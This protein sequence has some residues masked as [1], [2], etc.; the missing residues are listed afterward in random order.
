[1]LHYMY[2]NLLYKK[3]CAQAV[4]KD[5]VLNQIFPVLVQQTSNHTLISSQIMWTLQ[6]S[7]RF[8]KTY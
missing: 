1:M 3:L 6:S 5:L 8:C 4:K 2:S 7:P